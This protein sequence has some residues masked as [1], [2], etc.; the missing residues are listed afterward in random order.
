MP[1]E[2]CGTFRVCF[3]L[4]Q[5]HVGRPWDGCSHLTRNSQVLSPFVSHFQFRL[6]QFRFCPA[7]GTRVKLLSLG[8]WFAVCVR[9]GGVLG[10]Q[11]HIFTLGGSPG[12]WMWHHS[13]EHITQKAVPS[14]PVLVCEKPEPQ[15]S[16]ASKMQTWKPSPESPAVP[17]LAYCLYSQARLLVVGIGSQGTSLSSCPLGR[18]TNWLPFSLTGPSW[19][20]VTGLCQGSRGELSTP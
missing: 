16:L 2:L 1:S 9:D 11:F 10:R 13:A 7:E 19:Q 20:H 6:S 12:K 5:C 8:G 14:W 17:P 18:S 15:L 3:A 4:Y